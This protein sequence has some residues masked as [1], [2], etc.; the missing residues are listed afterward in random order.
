TA[1]AVVGQTMFCLLAAVAVFTSRSWL[2]TPRER[3]IQKDA[4]P[5]V[6]H[7]WM[8]IGFLYLQL[9][10]GAAF[11]HV[12]TK[13]GPMGTGQWPVHKIV[14]TFLY[15]HILNA[16]LVT[17]LIFYVALRVLVKHQK[18]SHLKWPACWLL[19]LL[20]LQIILGVGSYIVRVVLGP[21][22]LQPTRALVG[23]TVMHMAVG[24]LILAVAFILTI[25][26]YR[27]R[28]DSAE[29]LPFD[30]RSEVASA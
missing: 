20:F 30:R 28:G 24:A 23:I 6:R 18:I 8:L 2:E 5:L 11:R 14:H 21:D 17:A 22:E 26:A 7:C 15:P 4:R 16:L 19:V 1:H 10:L 25:Q 3:I 13:W 9:G 29:V 12:W 27:H